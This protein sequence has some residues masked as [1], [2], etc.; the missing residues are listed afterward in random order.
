METRAPRRRYVGHS[1][2]VKAVLNLQFRS[3]ELLISGGADAKIIV[4]DL[5]S[6]A[7]LHTLAGHTMGIQ[8]LV[9]DPITYKPYDNTC[10]VDIFSASSDRTIRRWSL[11]PT[12]NATDDHIHSTWTAKEVD[13]SAPITVH[14]TSVYALH[15]SS[16]PESD[17]D[18]W[19]A[20][21]DGTVKCLERQ[22]NWEA[23]TTLEH[24]DYVR[25]V[26]FVNDGRGNSW[27]VSGGRDEEI[28]VWNTGVS[29]HFRLGF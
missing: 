11:I 29:Y 28:K 15:F 8:T 24:G 16:D 25:T 26:A 3:Q 12:N 9:L 21:A 5:A 7:K 18:L 13:P 1:D 2:F 17:C 4:W 20:S 27:V 14:E 22:R 6:G 23:D 10:S 19:T